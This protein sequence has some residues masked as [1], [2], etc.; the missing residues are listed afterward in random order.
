MIRKEIVPFTRFLE[1][2]ILAGWDDESIIQQMTRYQLFVGGE[3][4]EDIRHELNEKTVCKAMI[5]E[6]QIR[7]ENEEEPLIDKDVKAMYKYQED[8]K[9]LINNLSCAT[10]IIKRAKLQNVECAEILLEDVHRYLAEN[11]AMTFMEFEVLEQEA[12]KSGIRLFTE[13]AYRRHLYWFWNIE[14]SDQERVARYVYHH[15]ERGLYHQ[16]INPTL[17]GIQDIFSPFNEP[18][19][20]EIIRKI[21]INN[22]KYRDKISRDLDHGRTPDKSDISRFRSTAVNINRLGHHEALVKTANYLERKFGGYMR[23]EQTTYIDPDDILVVPHKNFIRLLIYIGYKLD[24]VEGILRRYCFNHIPKCFLED[25]YS[26]CISFA[27]GKEMVAENQKRMALKEPLFDSSEVR[28]TFHYK[29]IYD[30]AIQWPRAITRRGVFTINV[31][32]KSEYKRRVFDLAHIVGMRYRQLFD[33][34]QRHFKVE[35]TR[36][37]YKLYKYYCWTLPKFPFSKR[38]LYQYLQQD[39]TNALYRSYKSFFDLEP[40]DLIMKLGK[41]TDKERDMSNREMLGKL[42]V[43]RS[44]ALQDGTPFPNWMNKLLIKLEEKYD[45]LDEEENKEYYRK[46]LQRIFDRITGKVRYTMTRDQI[47]NIRRPKKI[48]TLIVQDEPKPE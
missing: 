24:E 31:I 2:S 18:D 7:L 39:P 20:N 40:L 45:E 25:I 43:Y 15:K 14:D 37:D 6:N 5:T 27:E 10:K 23:N 3:E 17:E 34:W 38:G 9:A 26:G 1:V 33:L 46:Q 36:N 8:F 42:F 48:E 35:L 13:D 29:T 22:F 32:L 30:A 4:I 11:F 47:K 41:F 21:K 19:K 12:E 44:I 16:Y 28:K